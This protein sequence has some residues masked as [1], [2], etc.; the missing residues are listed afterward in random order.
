MNV[1]IAEDDYRLVMIHSEYVH[2]CSGFH[3]LGYA[4]NGQELFKRLDEEEQV[5]LLLLDLYFPDIERAKLL[6]DVRRNYP[7][8]DILIISASDD[9]AILQKA[10]RSG[11]FAFLQKPVDAALFKQ[12]LNDYAAQQTLFNRSYATFYN[13]DA[14]RVLGGSLSL[15]PVSTLHS[16]LPSGIDAITLQRVNDLLQQFEEG[17]TIEKTCEELGVSRTTAR[18]YLEHLVRESTVYTQ[19]SYGE[20]GRPERRYQ[21]KHH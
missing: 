7:D 2:A 1:L 10:K 19:L 5:D 12:T 13:E 8:L 4:L 11:V 20:I 3:L 21:L 6:Q 18:R 15:K 17:L 14:A 16:D 9:M